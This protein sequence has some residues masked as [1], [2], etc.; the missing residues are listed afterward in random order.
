MK[1]KSWAWKILV[2]SYWL[3]LNG[4]LRLQFLADVHLRGCQQMEC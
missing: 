4:V 2:E 3:D 1:C